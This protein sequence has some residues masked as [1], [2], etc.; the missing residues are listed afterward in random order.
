MQNYYQ[1]VLGFNLVCDQGWAKIYRSS[2]S[3]FIGLVDEL[4]GM[5]KFTKEKA[6]VVSFELDDLDGWY[7]YSNLK[8]YFE[9]GN[10]NPEL[11]TGDN[12]SFF[13]GV[14][15]EGYHIRFSNS[16]GLE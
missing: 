7:N 16:V 5:H 4:R 6:V 14:D 15:P 1:D 11:I 9:S 8:S 13:T 10:K 12:K 3:G 2:E